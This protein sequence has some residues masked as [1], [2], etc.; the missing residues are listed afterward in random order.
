MVEVF[1]KLE[2][3]D[4]SRELWAHYL[5]RLKRFFAANDLKDGSRRR[6]FFLSAVGAQHTCIGF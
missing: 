6:A 3:F 5:E 4:S 2:E 1:S